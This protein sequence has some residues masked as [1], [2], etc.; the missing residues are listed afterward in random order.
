MAQTW[1]AAT[2][3]QNGRF[4]ADLADGAFALLAPH[5]GERI[6]DLGCGDGILSERIRAA[7]AT[8]VGV[9]SSPDLVRAAIAR[10]IDGRLGDG[11]RL[12]FRNEFDAVF[13][14]AA[15][16]WMVDQHA[17]LSGVRTALRTGGRFVAEMGGHGNIAAIRTALQAAVAPFGLDA[18]AAGSNVFFTAIEYRAML[19]QRGFEVESIELVPRPTL[20]PTGL[21]GWLETFRRSLLDQLTPE[22]KDA[23]MARATGLLKP[24]FC[25]RS[26]QWYADYV[27]LRFQA[28]ART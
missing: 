14:N 18:E 28:T 25:D 5:P 20:L 23:V 12:Q 4:V 22:Q 2:Y 7:G 9:D 27:R 16:H 21:A 24:I 26:G 17:V 10:G 13:S 19:E 1:C 8:V 3:E 6:L 11:Q 15:L